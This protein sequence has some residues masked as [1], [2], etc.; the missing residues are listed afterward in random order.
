MD[1]ADEAAAAIEAGEA[2]AFVDITY[3]T[4]EK[5]NLTLVETPAPLDS[6]P[7]AL[8]VAKGDTILKEE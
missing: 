1:S 8:A 7:V 3:D 5:R 6:K 4:H 2:V